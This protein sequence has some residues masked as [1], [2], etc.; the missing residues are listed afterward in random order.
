MLNIVL[1]IFF[2]LSLTGIF[3][4][5]YKKIPVLANISLE[6]LQNRESFLAFIKRL[7]KNFLL[8][9]HPKKIKI[10]FLVLAE[11]ILTRSRATTLKMHKTMDVLSQ[12]MKKRSQQEKWK[13]KWFSPANEKEKEEN[14]G[15]E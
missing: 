4:I 10:Y 9:I 7:F 12:D 6:S 13:S 1:P 11:K 15:K 8:S 14:K 3:Y 5:L 2:F